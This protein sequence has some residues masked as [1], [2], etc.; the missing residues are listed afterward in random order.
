M[1]R[2][3]YIFAFGNNNKIANY[4]KAVLGNKGAAL[5]Q[6]S[7]LDINIPPGF[8][9]S[10]KAYHQYDKNSRQLP[11]FLKNDVVKAL[12]ALEQKTGLIFGVLF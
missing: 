1:S 12:R 2:E 9:I 3:Q 11:E 8:T 5:A 6:M 4:D 10:T 7:A